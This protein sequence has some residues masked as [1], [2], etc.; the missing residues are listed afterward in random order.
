MK[1]FV[2]YTLA[3][4]CGIFLIHLFAF[5]L[6]M[7]MG[8][9]LSFIG[10]SG[11]DIKEHSVL[12]INMAGTLQEQSSPADPFTTLVGG[13]NFETQGLSQI[14]KAIQAAKT[15]D[16]IEGIFLDG[17]SLSGDVASMQ[18][19]RKQLA[20]F[21]TSGKWI[22]AY[23]EQYGQ[24]N[25][26]VA[27]VADSIVINPLGMIDWRGISSQPIFFTG[28]L[29]KLGVKMQVFKVGTYKSAVEPYILTE[30]SDA[31]REQVSS[32]IGDIWSVLAADVSKSRKVSVEQ[33]NTYADSYVT[34]AETKDYVKMRLADR[35]AYIDE[36]RTSL[37]KLTD[38][39]Q[40]RFVSVSQM[41]AQQK[42]KSSSKQVAVYVAE[43]SIVDQASSSKFGSESEIVGSTVVS[44]LDALANDDDVKAVVLRINSGGGSAYASEQ[45]WRAIQL[46]KKKKPVV[47]SMS[48]MAA[49]GGYYMSCGA[50]YIFAEPT[51]ITGSIGIFA[52]IPDASQLLNEKLGLSFD[53]VKTNASSDFAAMGRP[54]NAEESEAMQAYVN[55]GYRLFIS[56][57]A[58]GRTAAGFKM[59]LDDVDKIGQGRVWTGQQALKLGLVDQLGS[60]DMAIEKAAELAKMKKDDYAIAQ[61]PAPKEWIEKLMETAQGDDYLERKLHTTL[62]EYYE[63]LRFIRD[64]DRNSML[65]ARMFYLP[66][67]R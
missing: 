49:S 58:A 60:L 51:T 12:R 47:V 5:V 10:S 37:S 64:A 22:Y 48:G 21:K 54:F 50:N 13:E 28:L 46:L 66:N 40:V 43:G 65:Q 32:F 62:G 16:N 30:M 9:A 26:Y 27:S 59:T 24:S 61:Y 57:V 35:L 41:A 31:N 38:E 17:G 20:D 3:T 36:V 23:A 14:V 52:M 7:V 34:F 55:R 39:D 18:Y 25:Y 6:F 45:M 1:D 29:E 63:P 15:D 19:L 8:S 53:V 2:K 56:R 4:M 11:S 33:L 67:I 42:P 44:D